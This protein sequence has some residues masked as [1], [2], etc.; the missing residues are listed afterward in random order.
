MPGPEREQ[1]LSDTQLSELA[2]RKTVVEAKGLPQAH[3]TVFIG[4]KTYDQLRSDYGL[5]DPR[6]PQINAQQGGTMTMLIDASMGLDSTVIDRS[7][8]IAKAE[9]MLYKDT[10][11]YKKVGAWI[12]R[13]AATEAGTEEESNDP[14]PDIVDATAIGVTAVLQAF[15]LGVGERFVDGLG[16]VTERDM[17]KAFTGKKDSPNLTNGRRSSILEELNGKKSTYQD[18]PADQVFL[19]DFIEE[20]A[21]QFAPNDVD[22]Y[23]KEGALKAYH[24]IDTLWSRI[25]AHQVGN[26]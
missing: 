14:D 19:R 2:L 21:S 18:I 9:L 10:P 3:G 17:R 13:F 5:D 26:A 1:P 7:V 11:F 20:L 22:F 8:K 23:V 25:E 15:H 4:E 24:I 16:A 6:N 12:E